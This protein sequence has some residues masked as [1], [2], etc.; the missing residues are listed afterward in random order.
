MSNHKT[1][2]VVIWAPSDRLFTLYPYFIWTRV[3]RINIICHW[4]IY[5]ARYILLCML[6]MYCYSGRRSLYTTYTKLTFYPID[7]TFWC[8]ECWTDIG[9]IDRWGEI[10]WTI[11]YNVRPHLFYMYVHVHT[12]LFPIPN[13][14]RVVKI[15]L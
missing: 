12:I 7:I 5:M 13:Y 8:S 2:L 15:Y 9:W 3:K 1:V 6:Y 4:V 11:F 10:L 14:T